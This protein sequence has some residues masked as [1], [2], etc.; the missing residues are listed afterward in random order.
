M[1]T[2]DCVA[3]PSPP[4]SPCVTPD[5]KLPPVA[6]PMA[7]LERSLDL[8]FPWQHHQSVK[9]EHLFN[10]PCGHSEKAKVFPQT[11]HVVFKRNQEMA[12]LFLGHIL[13]H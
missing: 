7:P 10:V 6:K 11:L 13:M 2:K 5:P 4:L 8:V 9:C 3:A 1:R 12:V